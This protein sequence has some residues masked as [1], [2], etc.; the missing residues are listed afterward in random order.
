VPQLPHA[1]AAEARRL[2]RVLLLWHG[3]LPAGAA[4]P[5]LLS[6]LRRPLRRERFAHFSDAQVVAVDRFQLS[7]RSAARGLAAERKI[8]LLDTALIDKG[9]IP[10]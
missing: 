8:P 10:P 4:G 9:E 6:C 3:P 7:V 2:L 1:A 5:R